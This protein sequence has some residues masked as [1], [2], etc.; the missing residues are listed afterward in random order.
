MDRLGTNTA[1]IRF[2]GVSLV[3]PLVPLDQRPGQAPW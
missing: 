3:C 2:L 1:R